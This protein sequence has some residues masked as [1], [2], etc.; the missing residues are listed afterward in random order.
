DKGDKQQYSAEGEIEVAADVQEWSFR[1]ADVQGADHLVL[2]VADRFVGRD[3][4]V[5]EDEGTVAPGFSAAENIVGHLGRHEG[6]GGAIAGSVPHAGGD[7][8]ITQEYRGSPLD[9]TVVDDPGDG[10]DDTLI[11]VEH[12]PGLQYPDHAAILRSQGG[13]G[14]QHQALLQEGRPC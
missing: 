1:H 6:A 13:G 8:H 12:Q 3:E 5:A 10:I 9:F 7:A 4:P 11:V 14:N 2:G